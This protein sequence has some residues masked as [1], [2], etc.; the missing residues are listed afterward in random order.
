MKKLQKLKKKNVHLKKKKTC[1]IEI[2]E[3]P[4]NAGGND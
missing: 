1:T 4:N 3:T 2:E